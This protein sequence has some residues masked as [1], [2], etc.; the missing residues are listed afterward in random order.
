MITTSDTDRNGRLFEVGNVYK[1]DGIG[2]EAVGSDA[3]RDFGSWISGG[4]GGNRTPLAATGSDP[5]AC[6]VD[7]ASDGTPRNQDISQGQMARSGCDPTLTVTS[8]AAASHR[9]P[10]GRTGRPEAT[11]TPS[12]GLQGR[13]RRRRPRRSAGSR[14]P[15]EPPLH[16]LSAGA[17]AGADSLP[18]PVTRNRARTGGPGGRGAAAGRR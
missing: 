9:I 12:Y 17:D 7:V 18:A 4:M 13:R 10:G 8:P 1:V 15:G 3:R 11:T 2:T 14:G 5:C 6:P 16:R